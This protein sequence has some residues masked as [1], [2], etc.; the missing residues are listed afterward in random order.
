MNVNACSGVAR[1]HSQHQCHFWPMKCLLH[2]QV[3]LSAA[4][5]IYI[6]HEVMN[7]C[8]NLLALKM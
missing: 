2:G 5:H 1:C 6:F 4:N 3:R 8:K 7:G